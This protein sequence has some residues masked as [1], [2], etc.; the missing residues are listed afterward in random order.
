MIIRVRYGDYFYPVRHWA[1]LRRFAVGNEWDP[2]G[3]FRLSDDVWEG[4]PYAVGAGPTQAGVYRFR[5]SRLRSFIRL[6]AK[7]YLYGLL[8][9]R[10]GR[11]SGGPPRAI[12]SLGAVDDYVIEHG[13]TS[14]DD[15]ASLAV[16]KPLW[17]ALVNREKYMADEALPASAISKQ[18]DTR[19]FWLTMRSEFGSPHIVLPLAPHASRL[20]AEFSCDVSRIV[21]EA[22]IKQLSNKLALHRRG[23]EALLPGDHLRLCVLMLQTATGRRVSEI[24]LAARGEGPEGPLVRLPSR[25]G[26]PT[27]SL[28]F[29]FTPNKNG[30]GDKAYISPEWEGIVSYCVRELI[31]YGDELRLFAIKEERHLLILISR[32]NRTKGRRDVALSAHGRSAECGLSSAG[33]DGAVIRECDHVSGL[34]RAGFR[35][36]LNGCKSPKHPDRAV[37]GI[38]EVWGITADGTSGGPVYVFRTHNARHTRQS[39]IAEDPRVPPIALQRDLNHRDGDMQFAYQHRSRE[40]NDA[41][42]KKLE[43]GF[44]VG[45]GREWLAEALGVKRDGAA[46]PGLKRG[47]PSLLDARWRLL[48][49]NNPLFVQASRVPCGF[50][51]LPQ[52]PSACAEYMN[53]TAASEGG[54]HSFVTD[55]SDRQMMEELGAKARRYRRRQEESLKAGRRIQSEKLD[56]LARRTEQLHGEALSRA[57]TR[58]VEELNRA[59]V[60]QEENGLL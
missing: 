18:K 30:P 23:A 43:G 8:L 60:E 3:L 56:V 59:A 9:G 19:R 45:R 32:L 35:L 39:V 44:L 29:V 42:L 50:C 46:S 48:V 28:W 52:G 53:C 49:L 54:C 47:R 27:G 40:S 24:L 2:R 58:M 41:L 16:F 1:R 33:R 13:F 20:P 57:S 51:V 17:G 22:V 21:P 55:A 34:D 25:G 26:G 15:L 6:Y 4:W 10:G 38:M 7:W 12:Y 36:W 11:L 5:F 31:R 37:K 14:L